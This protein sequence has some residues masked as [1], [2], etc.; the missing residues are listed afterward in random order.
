MKLLI[1]LGH[2]AHFHLFRF[3]IQALRKNGHQITILARNKDVLEDLL[4]AEELPFINVLPRGRKD[5]TA[6][7]M[8]AMLIRER[9]IFREALRD[10][11][12]LMVGTCAEIG[13]VGRMLG[14]PSIVVNE[15]DWDV[16]PIFAKLA[17]P[18]CNYILAPESCRT[19]RWRRKTISYRGY[20]ELAYLHPNHF[21]PDRSVV[22]TFHPAEGPYF[23][24]RFAKL[25]AH[26]DAGRRGIGREVARRLVSTLETRGA[27]YITSERELEPEFE[28]Y[29]IKIA[30][31]KIHHAMAFAEL[32]VGDSQTMAAEAAVL[33]TPAIRFNDFVGEIGYL[34]ELEDRYG[35]TYGVRTNEPERMFRLV[36][37]YS[38]PGT[39][40]VWDR[41]RAAMLKEK[42]DVAAFMAGLFEGYPETV[43]ELREE[44]R[45]EETG[46]GARMAEHVQ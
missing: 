33:G 8:G 24:I 37:N 7:M 23:L 31:D 1:Y 42:I 22:R 32:Y 46:R 29:R 38:K 44:S 13:H 17:Y 43:R 36:E 6:G 9:A 40:K 4:H 30:P 11:P 18:F 19:G 14:I 10:R 28:S 5:T 2:P 39:K 27:V 12:N 20:H 16:V 21:T 34:E 25:A 35:L 41:R 45:R 26:H 15:D 3:V